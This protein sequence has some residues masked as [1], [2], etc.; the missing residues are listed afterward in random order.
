MKC[1]VSFCP[2]NSE[3]N[4]RSGRVRKQFVLWTE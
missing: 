3:W 2:G 4:I 1:V